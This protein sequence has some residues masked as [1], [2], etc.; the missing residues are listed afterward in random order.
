MVVSLSA[1]VQTAQSQSDP[2]Q[3]QQTPLPGGTQTQP[4]S[5]AT[6]TAPPETPVSPLPTGSEIIVSRLQGII[7][8]SDPAAVQ[9]NGVTSPGLTVRDTATLQSQAFL[10]SIKPLLGQPVTFDR[11]NE[12]SRRVVAFYRKQGHPFVNVTVPPQNIQSGTVQFLV[13]EYHIGRVTVEGTRWFSVSTIRRGVRLKP[14]DPIDDQTLADDIDALNENPFRHVGAIY[15][16]GA[17]AGTTDLVLKTEDRF[18]M[19]FSGTFDNSGTQATGLA[20]WGLGIDWGNAFWLGHALSFQY[21]SSS[22]LFQDRT[23][24]D[25]ASLPPSFQGYSASYAIALPLGR[26]LSVSG[27]YQQQ[28]PRLGESL[29]E[30][31]INGQASIRY[32][33]PLGLLFGQ[34]QRIAAGYDF[35]T[36]NNN[37]S[38]GGT[39]VFASTTQI[40]QFLLDYTLEQSDG[41]GR[42]TAGN[43]LVLSPGNLTPLNNNTTF[44]QNM[45]GAT[46]RYAYDRINLTRITPL[47]LGMSAVTFGTLQFASQNLLASEQLCG[48]GLD[49]IPGYELCTISG[50]AGYLFRQEV[51]SPSFSLFRVV[52]LG[53]RADQMQFDAFW[54]YTALHNKS[55]TAGTPDPQR[56]ESLGIGVRYAFDRYLSFR[57]E[58]GWQLLAAPG[59]SSSG[60]FGN[61]A[62]TVAF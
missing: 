14:G 59:H 1:T 19:R 4:S 21:Q 45:P 58:Y 23:P 30:V 18:P 5:P 9:P 41:W 50:S 51:R 55:V 32:G 42:T 7:F 22:D 34:K 39:Q 37:L 54:G 49:T 20:R 44:Q 46:A 10:D 53:E 56:I 13:T 33:I 43:E 27:S 29:G 52:G 25:G 48:G 62:L 2:S 15:R 3:I 40:N 11:L 26:S 57:L 17:E 36:S 31:G 28:V 12:I 16:P 47:P 6:R 35:K 8:V 24:P 61:F 38:F 60:S